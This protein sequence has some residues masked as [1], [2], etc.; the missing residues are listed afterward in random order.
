[1]C[2]LLSMNYMSGF[3]IQILIWLR[4]HLRGEFY[5]N[6][7]LWYVMSP[8]A[9]LSRPSNGEMSECVLWVRVYLT[10]YM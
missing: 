2:S 3:H 6:R 10:V 7:D 8:P 9:C 1:M 4:R 5:I